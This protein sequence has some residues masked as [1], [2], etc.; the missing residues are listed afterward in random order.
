MPESLLLRRY[1]LVTGLIAFLTATLVSPGVWFVNALGCDTWGHDAGWFIGIC[2]DPRYGDYGDNDHGA[3]YFEYQK[4]AAD[5]ARQAEVLIFGN[6]RTLFAL[7]SEGT[8]P[9]FAKLGLKYFHLGFG[10]DEH[11]TFALALARKLKL[12]PKAIIINADPFFTGSMSPVG[13][14]VVSETWQVR[15]RYWGKWLLNQTQVRICDSAP[16]LCR[17]IRGGTIFRSEIDGGWRLHEA[18]SP[19]DPIT[20]VKKQPIAIETLAP[21]IKNGRQFLDQFGLDNKCII[22][23]GIPNSLNNSEEVAHHLANAF[24][25]VAV[26]PHVADLATTDGS[27]FTTP[28]ADRWRMTFF[29]ELEPA[30]AS[31]LQR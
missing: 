29:Q 8:R 25:V 21:F 15:S 19:V 31:C 7:P 17:P 24:G 18:L 20:A 13:T 9:Y 12:R 14:A 3:L 16:W 10:H 2:T 6:S 27:H 11:D 5:N 26:I 22:F 30:L 1:L 4:A 23:T 28:S